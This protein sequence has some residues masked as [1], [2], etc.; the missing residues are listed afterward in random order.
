MW[1]EV[2]V[3]MRVHVRVGVRRPPW[4]AFDLLSF[5]SLP[6][7]VSEWNS[8]PSVRPHFYLP[9]HCRYLLLF[10]LW[11]FSRWKIAVYVATIFFL[12]SVLLSFW[13][14]TSRFLLL[15]FLPTWQLCANGMLS[16]TRSPSHCFI[17]LLSDRLAPSQTWDNEMF[18]SFL[19]TAA[20]L[21]SFSSGLR[22]INSRVVFEREPDKAHLPW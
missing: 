11:T 17:A 6:V 21:H 10:T 12:S 9:S 7:T 20:M 5:H 8:Y 16:L 2:C 19:N 22:L 1:H 15:V 3:Y 14:L 4:L 18:H 13:L